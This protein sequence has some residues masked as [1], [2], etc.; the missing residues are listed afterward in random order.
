MSYKQALL[1]GLKTPNPDFEYKVSIMHDFHDELLLAERA[2]KRMPYSRQWIFWPGVLFEVD[3]QFAKLSFSCEVRL[4]GEHV[5]R[6]CKEY[7][8]HFTEIEAQEGCM[9]GEYQCSVIVQRYL[10]L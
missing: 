8:S 4:F 5:K 10:V 6:I 2:Y 1:K 7:F 3:D 9:M